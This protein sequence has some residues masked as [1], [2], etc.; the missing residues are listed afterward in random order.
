MDTYDPSQAIKAKSK[1][2]GYLN[3]KAEQGKATVGGAGL[4]S[5]SKLI[6]DEYIEDANRYVQG[7]ANKANLFGS[8]MNLVGGL[9]QIGAMGGFSGGGPTAEI[10]GKT[11]GVDLS[12]GEIADLSIE[13][14]GAGPGNNFML[15]KYF[16]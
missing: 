7:Q 15:P 11:Y 4:Q 8:A 2:Q 6:A 16:N 9:G 1:A 12:G 13:T 3:A 14:T 10:G 5:G